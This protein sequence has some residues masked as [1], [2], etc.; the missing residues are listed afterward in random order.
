MVVWGSVLAE[1]FLPR[2]S[3]RPHP[4]PLPLLL[5]VLGERGLRKT[6]SFGKPPS[7][8]GTKGDA[9][10]RSEIAGVCGAVRGRRTPPA[11]SPKQL[12]PIMSIMVFNS[13]AETTHQIAYDNGGV[14]N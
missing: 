11:Q 8:F 9:S 10:K 6:T 13:D 5:G 2:P 14:L 1:S 4:S 12:Q 7:P 3:P